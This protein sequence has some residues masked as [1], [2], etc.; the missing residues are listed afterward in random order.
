MTVKEF[1]ESTIENII[2]FFS[3][4]PVFKGIFSFLGWLLT[5]MY[6]NVD[7]AMQAFLVLMF[8]DLITGLIKA[9]VRNEAK[10]FISHEKGR[11][12]YISYAVVLFVAHMLDT[13]MIPGMRNIAL[14]WGTATEARSIM[15][16][17]ELM[18]VPMPEFI[19]EHLRKAEQKH[20]IKNGGKK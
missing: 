17:F 3:E 14:F 19:K 18:G 8:V 7:M 4:S 12:K 6:G 5:R 1:I 16:N 15:E 13:A 10:S 2:R 11:K 9:E 20:K